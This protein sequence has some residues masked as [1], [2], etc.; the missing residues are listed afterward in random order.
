MWIRIE[1]GLGQIRMGDRLRFAPAPGGMSGGWLEM[2]GSDFGGQF[3]P[4]TL[5]L[6][7]AFPEETEGDWI[8]TG[9][10]KGEDGPKVRIERPPQNKFEIMTAETDSG[11]DYFI[12]DCCTLCG[13][14][15]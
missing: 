2:V 14:E 9:M 13:E 5:S 11:L 7:D 3:H 10:H 6:S 1:G 12:P 4:L 8:L 15:T